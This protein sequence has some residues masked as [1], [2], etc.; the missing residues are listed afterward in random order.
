MGRMASPDEFDDYTSGGLCPY[1]YAEDI[2]DDGTEWEG[3]KLNR[4][5]YCTK[6]EKK[7]TEV[8]TMTE[9]FLDDADD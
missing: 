3:R 5:K 1:C 9:L 2:V 7:W 4:K 6:C 8:F